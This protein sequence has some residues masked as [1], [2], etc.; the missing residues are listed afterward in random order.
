MTKATLSGP[1]FITKRAANLAKVVVF[2]TPAG[3]ISVTIPP[4]ETIS[5]LPTCNL[6][7]T[8]EANCLQAKLNEASE[9]ILSD[10]AKATFLSKPEPKSNS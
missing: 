7:S 4:C 8:I 9:S 10:K 5:S 1:N 2:P 3:P 6:S